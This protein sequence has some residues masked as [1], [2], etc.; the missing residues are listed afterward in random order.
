MRKVLCLLCLLIFGMALVACNQS[1]KD[2]LVVGMECDYAPFNWTET[3]ESE[4]NV[5]ISN[6]PGAY[7]EGYDVQIAKKIAEGLGM[8]L[9]IKSFVWDGL[10]PALNN[11]EIDL[12]IA[13]MSP[14]EE[15][16]LSIDFT[17]GYY[18]STHV[19][20]VRKDST[21]ANAT[22][23]ED[24]T[25][26]KVAGQINTL[27]ADLVPQLVAK[28]AVKGEDLKTVPQLVQNLKAGVIDGTILE[29][30]VA[31]GLCAANSE[32]SYV[33]FAQGFDVAEEDVLVSIG[34]R[35]GYEHTAKINEI[36]AS[37]SEQTRTEIMGEAVEKN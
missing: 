3:K 5:A 29:E 25:G 13:G 16:K 14:T 1:E 30:P 15:R 35:K 17:E 27:Y 31:I 2:V 11:G 21:Y 20:L 12:I 24:F 37:I 10:I 6:V 28:G 8:E 33:K 18:R 36:L 19:V 22:T 4:T 32:L 34:V 9:E 26:A 7:A 23:M